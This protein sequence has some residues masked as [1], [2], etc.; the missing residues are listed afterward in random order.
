MTEEF[1]DILFDE[2]MEKM[3]DLGYDCILSVICIAVLCGHSFSEY[4]PRVLCE[5]FPIMYAV[6]C[7]AVCSNGTTSLH[8]HN[9]FMSEQ[10]VFIDWNIGIFQ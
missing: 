6:R 5:Q 10:R 4:L 8:I 1:E 7:G 2:I 9:A 3:D